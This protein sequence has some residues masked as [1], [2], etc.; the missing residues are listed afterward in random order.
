MTMTAPPPPKRRRGRPRS[1]IHQQVVRL[2]RQGERPAG[3]ARMLILTRQ[4]ISAI[5]K[6]AGISPLADACRIHSQ[7]DARFQAIWEAA[8]ILGLTPDR[9]CVRASQLR[10][11]GVQLKYFPRAPRS[12]KVRA[13]MALHRQGLTA[14]EIIRRGVAYPSTV[15]KVLKQFKPAGSNAGRVW[16]AAE[17]ALLAEM[18]DAEVAAR[19]GRKVSAVKLR[20]WTLRSRAK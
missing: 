1:D 12:T 8:R 16:S 14:R 11:R 7:A 4:W 20:R 13:I 3:I 5:L 2:Y 9:A 10:G 6:G 19:T 18:S 15:Y 17:D